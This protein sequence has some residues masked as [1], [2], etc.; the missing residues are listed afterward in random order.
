[1]VLASGVAPGVFGCVRGAPP[2]PDCVG[3][4]VLPAFG[5]FAGTRGPP[6]AQYAGDELIVC[7]VWPGIG[8]LN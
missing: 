7:G 5:L 8:L 3:G 6:A 2:P 1:V 4:S